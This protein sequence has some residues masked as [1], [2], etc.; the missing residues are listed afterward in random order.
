MRIRS[1]AGAALAAALLGA[2]VATAQTTAAPVTDVGPPPAEERS[3]TGAV[4]L[5][6]SPVQA[7]KK[8]FAESTAKSGA[9]PVGRGVLRATSRA[10]TRAELAKARA[11]EATELRVRGAGVLT[12][13]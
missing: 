13:R 9:G 11:D 7:Q 6:N 4:V 12:G 1:L 2:A 5:E 10:Q 3:S 8:A